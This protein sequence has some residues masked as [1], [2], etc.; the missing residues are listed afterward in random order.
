MKKYY[1]LIN[2][3]C[4]IFYKTYIKQKILNINVFLQIQPFKFKPS[5]YSAIF[6]SGQYMHINI[7]I[8]VLEIGT[9]TVEG[10]KLITTK[11]VSAHTFCVLPLWSH[12]NTELIFKVTFSRYTATRFPAFIYNNES[13]PPGLNHKQIL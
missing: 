4:M 3:F 6:S 13:K 1:C 5:N 12:F 7:I 2:I 10:N 9:R 8:H 11:N